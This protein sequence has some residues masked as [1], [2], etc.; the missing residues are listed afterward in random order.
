MQT[1]SHDTRGGLT[2]R[3]VFVVVA[4]AAVMLGVLIPSIRYSRE[5]AR[6]NQCAEN[7]RL[8]GVA[9]TGFD[10]AYGRLPPGTAMGEGSAWSLYILPFLEMPDQDLLPTIPQIGEGYPWAYPQ[11]YEDSVDL[12]PSFQGVR[13]CENVIKPYR[14]PAAALPEH[15][16][17]VSTDGYWVMRRSPVSYLG[18]ASGRVKDQLVD[19]EKRHEL[20]ENGI[21]NA[22]GMLFGIDQ[23]SYPDVAVRLRWALDGAAQTALVGEAL[24]DAAAVTANGT[25]AEYVAGSRKDHWWGG[26]D[27]VDTGGGRDPSEFL[28]STGVGINLSRNAGKNDAPCDDPDSDACQA[29][30][31]SFSSNHP[32]VVHVVFCDGHYE[33]I[34]E[35]VDSVVWSSYGTRNN[36]AAVESAPFVRDATVALQQAESFDQGDEFLSE[37]EALVGKRQFEEAINA[38]RRFLDGGQNAVYEGSYLSEKQ[39]DATLGLASCLLRLQREK[40]A[41]PL[42]SDLHQSKLKR[43]NTGESRL[44]LELWKGLHDAEPD[45]RGDTGYAGL[46]FD[47][48]GYIMIPQLHF[49]GHPPWTLEVIAKPAA[50]AEGDDWTSLVSATDG[51]SIG[52]ES[53][54]GKWSI[55]LYTR[56]GFSQRWQENYSTAFADEPVSI[57]TWQHIA[58]VWDG[59]ELRIYVN[60]N[61]DQV[62]ESVDYCTQLSEGP[63]FVAAD[64]DD[65]SSSS[66]AQGHFQ[67]IIKAVRISR[68]ALYSD[69]FTSPKV[70]E[71]TEDTICLYDLTSESGEIA[72]DRSGH[73]NHGII[74]NASY[75]RAE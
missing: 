52:L 57:G 10:A 25:V 72:I 43:T 13:F 23:F 66:I 21:L 16:T 53:N 6:R 56:D 22:D 38:Y 27:D 59:S 8:I 2:R 9:L 44:I 31:L 5:N 42:L 29:W 46:S 35:S 75:E 37:A 41:V 11:K 1:S 71:K 47:G 65:I 74:I 15:Q 73:R 60:G 70:L 14:C 40:E 68:A 63:F 7:L 62:C 45:P 28:G 50:V 32:G 58:G 20:R 49:D 36:T 26:S 24:H 19:Y 64:P 17:D 18:V 54:G 39:T 30:Q 51:G 61:L 4:I 33:A 34:Q 69:S 67:G 48:N 55:S 3:D 12:G